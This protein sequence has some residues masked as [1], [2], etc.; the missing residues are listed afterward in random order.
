LLRFL[1]TGNA[2]ERE[3]EAWFALAGAYQAQNRFDASHE[4]YLKC[5]QFDESPF[6]ARACYQLAVQAIARN[7][8]DEAQDILTQSVNK[9]T[10]DGVEREVRRKSLFKLAELLY[11]RRQYDKAEIHLASAVNEFPNHATVMRLRD[12]LGDSRRHLA[13]RLYEQEKDAPANAR[14]YL[15][16]ER[17]SKLEDA[18]KVYEALSDE[19]RNRESSLTDTEKLLLQKARYASADCYYERELYLGALYRY[20]D[21]AQNYAGT[22]EGLLAYAKMMECYLN[23]RMGA[24]EKAEAE[25]TASSAIRVTAYHFRDI[26]D[27]AFPFPNHI[28]TKQYWQNRLAEHGALFK[29]S[30]PGRGTR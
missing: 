2:G 11:Q 23:P 1:H 29:L 14:G 18:G 27:A 8:L 3:A 10:G 20:A 6:A 5:M 9:A 17:L 28:Y 12:Y 22:K 4:A 19:L 13:W 15:R 24:G 25:P 26:P 21:C 16:R 30:M 7:H